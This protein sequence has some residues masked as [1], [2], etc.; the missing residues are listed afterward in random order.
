[1]VAHPALRATFSLAL[2]AR[3]KGESGLMLP[4]RGFRRDDEIE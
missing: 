2:R 3:A 4:P 1:M